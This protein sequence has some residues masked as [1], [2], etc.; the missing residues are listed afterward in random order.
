MRDDGS[1]DDGGDNSDD[2][3]SGGGRGNKDEE[4]KKQMEGMKGWRRCLCFA[5]RRI[6]HN[7]SCKITKLVIECRRHLGKVTTSFDAQCYTK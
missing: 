7:L 3:E 4:H 6:M 2:V 1:G 5:S